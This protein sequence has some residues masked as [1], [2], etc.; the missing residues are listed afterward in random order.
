MPQS[1]LG[2]LALTLASLISFNQQRVTQQ[3]YKATIRDE[4]E[5]AASGTA[6]HVMEMIAARSFDEVSTPT[7]VFDAGGVPRGAGLF[8][9]G[10]N[11][12]FG[13]YSR[14]GDCDLMTPGNTPRCDDV[15]D[16]DGTRGAPV[17]A[18]LSD[19]R[20]LRFTADVDVQYVTDPGGETTTN[21]PTLHKRV[22]VTIDSQ[23]PAAPV[24]G[25]IAVSR[26]I[27]YDPIKADMDAEMECGPIGLEGG[28]CDNSSTIPSQ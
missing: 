16:M 5:L 15:D 23:H 26:V 12:E 6:Q 8:T 22:D 10:N 24:Q 11:A 17:K 20:E 18:I 3:S 28:P 27:S 2:L 1:L 25:I 21:S 14:T 9:N 19:G 4:L 13:R 7:K